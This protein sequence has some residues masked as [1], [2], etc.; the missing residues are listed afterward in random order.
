MTDNKP[1][2]SL[3]DRVEIARSYNAPGPRFGVICQIIWVETAQRHSYKVDLGNNAFGWFFS[4]EIKK[5]D[6]V[7]AR[8]AFKIEMAATPGYAA[9]SE[10]AHQLSKPEPARVVFSVQREEAHALPGPD[11]AFYNDVFDIPYDVLDAKGVVVGKGFLKGC[12]VVHMTMSL[13]SSDNVKV[14]EMAV[15]TPGRVL[16][17]RTLGEDPVGGLIP[18][19]S[20]QFVTEATPMKWEG[21]VKKMLAQA[22]YDEP[23][24]LVPAHHVVVTPPNTLSD[25]YNDGVFSVG[26]RVTCNSTRSLRGIEG[27]VKELYDV[28]GRTSY[29]VDFGRGKA[30][31]WGAE[32]DLV[33]AV[34]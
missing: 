23:P 11:D 31:F 10:L 33:E 13:A 24:T 1:V 29:R 32:L 25:A 34:K 17:F 22:P 20:P 4:T 28:D 26:Q 3:N 2:F 15:E 16:P 30:W 9:F 19:S 27:E 8:P 14:E 6:F 21:D 7:P 12:M 5:T 18:P